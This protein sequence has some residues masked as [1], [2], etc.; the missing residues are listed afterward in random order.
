MLW[1]AYVLARPVLC[2]VLCLVSLSVLGLR[3]LKPCAADCGTSRAQAVWSVAVQRTALRSAARCGC[4]PGGEAA[5]QGGSLQFVAVFVWLRCGW[6]A[7]YGE[8]EHLAPWRGAEARYRVAHGLQ[9]KSRLKGPH[10][11]VHPSV[12]AD[13]KIMS[14]RA[15]ALGL[16][17]GEAPGALSQ[18]LAL[19]AAPTGGTP[20]G[21]G[22]NPVGGSRER[23][24]LCPR[25]LL[26]KS[27]QVRTERLSGAP[28]G[29]RTSPVVR[30]TVRGNPVGGSVEPTGP[31]GE[32]R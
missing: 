31:H 15:S 14:T 32:A 11:S 19:D 25:V 13:S 20:H 24:G 28:A 8:W 29:T 26:S 17:Q 12:F 7:M 3:R 6:E 10:P 9:A 1:C 27:P 18:G 23:L 16:A 5:G 30:R 2:L 21:V 4:H 22:T